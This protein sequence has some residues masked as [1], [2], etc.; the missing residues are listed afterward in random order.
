[1]SGQVAGVSEA[2]DAMRVAPGNGL[3]PPRRVTWTA[4]TR[5]PTTRGAGAWTSTT[6]EEG[7]GYR[8]A[9]VNLRFLAHALW[10]TEEA[11]RRLHEAA[12]RA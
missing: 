9:M 5:W 1:M 4:E 7:E 11:V 2:A 10:T 12:G 3:L 6:I 8:A